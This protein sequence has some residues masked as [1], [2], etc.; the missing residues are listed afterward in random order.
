MSPFRKRQKTA[1]SKVWEMLLR[2][3]PIQLCKRKFETMD[4]AKKADYACSKS[5]KLK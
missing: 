3:K 5:K 4:S 1:K 2:L